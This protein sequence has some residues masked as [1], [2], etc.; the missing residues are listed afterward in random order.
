M[1]PPTGNPDDRPAQTS[2]D[3]IVNA[4][5]WRNGGISEK[6]HLCDR[7]LR[8]GL[9]AIK[10]RIDALLES[11]DGGGDKDAELVELT[12][13]LGTLPAGKSSGGRPRR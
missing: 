10:A 9:R 5:V 7:C 2:N 1:V 11:L 8:I 6:T 4:S 3:L 12:E 13:R